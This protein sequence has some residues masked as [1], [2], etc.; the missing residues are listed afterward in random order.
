MAY[1][2]RRRK[3]VSL[4]SLCQAL[5]LFFISRKQIF[6]FSS[7]MHEWIDG[8]VNSAF[9]TTWGYPLLQ[10]HWSHPNFLP[11]NLATLNASCQPTCQNKLLGSLFW[12]WGG[13]AVFTF[14]SPCV[15]L[16][17]WNSHGPSLKD[18]CV[19]HPYALTRLPPLPTMT[20]RELLLW[21]TEKSPT[22]FV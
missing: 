16:K 22:L 13:A 14:L 4:F 17:L 15:M 11:W 7:V 8:Q 9:I 3:T 2:N 20:S 18:R 12:D 10:E 1:W 21:H 5:N 6:F 19:L